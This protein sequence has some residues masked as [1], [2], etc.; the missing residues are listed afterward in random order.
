MRVD[1]LGVCV[2]IRDLVMWEDIDT[3]LVEVDPQ[4]GGDVID[5]SEMHHAEEGAL[6]KLISIGRYMSRCPCALTDRPFQDTRE[7]LAYKPL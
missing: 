3:L 2:V 1:L 5:H 4:E 6:T 7:E